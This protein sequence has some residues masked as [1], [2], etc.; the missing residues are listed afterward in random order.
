[1]QNCSRGHLL[2]IYG[3]SCPNKNSKVA[4]RKN[5]SY[6]E[7]ITPTSL[8]KASDQEI[9]SIRPKILRNTSYFTNIPNFCRVPLSPPGMNNNNKYAHILGNLIKKINNELHQ[10]L[11]SKFTRKIMSAI[12]LESTVLSAFI[13]Q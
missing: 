1:M 5:E 6:F 4:W 11:N 8:F 7:S 12:V 2:I 10:R 3:C 13:S 9:S